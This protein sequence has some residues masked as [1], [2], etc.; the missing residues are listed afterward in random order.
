METLK[1]FSDLGLSR[2]ILR[3]VEDQGYENATAVQAGTIPAV[4]DG[5]DVIGLSHTGSGKTAAY[6]L[7]ALEKIRPE[8]PSLQVLILCPTRELALQVSGEIRKFTR[9]T[10]N[11]RALAVYGG[12]PIIRQIKAL[13]KGV[14]I[15][16]G[17]P[18]RIMDHMRR[19]T[20][21]T[22]S[23]H[24]VVLDEADEMLRMGF[25]E[26]ME[27]ILKEVPVTRQTLLFSATMPADI[28][29]IT[30]EF[31]TDPVLIRADQ[32]EQT[33]PDIEQFYYEVPREEK[34][35][36][37]ATLLSDHQVNRAL[38]FCNTRE[39]ADQLNGDL[40]RL[41]FNAASIHGDIRQET[42]GRIMDDFRAGR[43][44]VLVATDV[45]ARGIDVTGV[46]AVYNFD[47]PQSNEFYVHRIGRTGRAGRT[48]SAHTL[49]SGRGQLRSI[50]AIESLLKRRI[51]KKLL[52]EGSLPS[53]NSARQ[54]PARRNT[55][56][57]LFGEPAADVYVDQVHQLMEL[58]HD[59]VHLAAVL[60]QERAVLRAAVLA[61]RPERRAG[62]DHHRERRRERPEGKKDYSR[63]QGKRDRKFKG[64]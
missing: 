29:R 24:L 26:D 20:L 49:I 58:G 8:D 17:T 13:K 45:A 38:V 42:R 60:L 46:D 53:E 55:L 12:E 3:A 7:P 47:L 30:K 25:R 4:L 1:K 16:A 10:H 64:K 43:I 40:S 62:R 44:R 35:G 34:T 18:G 11:I 27:T 28:M 5:R 22:S 50:R 14:Q 6:V 2:D 32:D 61:D 63:Q 54:I 33:R 31:Q 9:Y 21:K 41:G 56:G 37:L 51:S 23:V 19:K 59:P 57:E 39:M 15:V 52:P 48:G 36:A